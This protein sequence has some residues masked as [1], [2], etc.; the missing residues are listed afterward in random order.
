MST[1]K[2]I[3]IEAELHDSGMSILQTGHERLKGNSG[4]KS[5]KEFNIFLRY[6]HKTLYNLPI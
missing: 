3:H 2:H 1:T 5:Q 4:Y 6:S